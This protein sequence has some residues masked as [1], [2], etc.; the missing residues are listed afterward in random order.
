M[1]PAIA[2]PL[3]K[4][5]GRFLIIGSRAMAIYRLLRNAPL[6]ESSHLFAAYELTLRALSRVDRNGALTVTIA[7]K[8]IEIGATGLRVPAEI[9]KRAV[10][11]LKSIRPRSAPKC[12][13]AVTAEVRAGARCDPLRPLG[14][15]SFHHFGGLGAEFKERVIHV[16][17][18]RNPM[19][20]ALSPCPQVDLVTVETGVEAVAEVGL[21]F[22]LLPFKLTAQRRMCAVVIVCR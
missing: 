1:A 3:R 7:N 20:T 10:K 17:L 2:G 5:W 11:P 22:H 15:A 13:H 18:Q 9:S 6:A 8:V 12:G 14:R 19:I 4:G 21:C 16:R